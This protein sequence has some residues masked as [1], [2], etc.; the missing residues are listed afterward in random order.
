MSTLPGSQAAY[1]ILER[2]SG[3]LG[4]TLGEVVQSETIFP[5]ICHGDLWTNNI[6][7]HHSEKKVVFVDFQVSSNLILAK[8]MLIIII[9]HPAILWFTMAFFS[10]CNLDLL[11]LTLGATS[12]QVSR[13]RLD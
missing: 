13:G 9:T 7:F 6:M 2:F 12:S 8:S 5:V 11:T 10:V 1:R 4:N 3:K